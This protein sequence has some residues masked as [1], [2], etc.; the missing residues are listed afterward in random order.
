LNSVANATMLKRDKCCLVNG[1]YTN[2]KNN[3]NEIRDPL[4]QKQ[5]KQLNEFKRLL[6]K[7]DTNLKNYT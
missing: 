3:N 6:N 2:T 5:S 7:I 4:E 1:I